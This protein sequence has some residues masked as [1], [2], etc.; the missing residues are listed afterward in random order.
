VDNPLL[1]ESGAAE[2]FAPQKGASTE[3][4]KLLNTGLTRFA[5]ILK[6]KTGKDVSNIKH[7]GAAGGTAA[8]LYGLFNARLMNGIEYFLELTKFAI[9]L[10][11]ADLV[12]T[13][14]GS[15]DEQ[16]LQGKAPF[17]VAVQAKKSGKPVIAL[18]G[19][20]L[21]PINPNLYTYFNVLFPIINAPGTLQKAIDTTEQNLSRTAREIGN[22]LRLS[23]LVENLK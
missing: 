22:I 17:G 10:K 2:V 1:G 8:G 19:Q 7:G 16:T 18:S 5:E 12:I 14:E 6:T 15:I 3:Q 23:P 20:L 4:V 11:D 9:A 21:L 13:G